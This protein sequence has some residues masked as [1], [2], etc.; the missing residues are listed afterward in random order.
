MTLHQINK[1]QYPASIERDWQLSLQ[2]GD[3]ILLFESG[4]LRA[5][6]STP[7]LSAQAPEQS[8]EQLKEQSTKQSVTL[9]VREIDAKAHGLKVDESIYQIIDDN[10]WLELTAECDRII[11]W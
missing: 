9:F 1:A 7:V 5:L 11:S 8:K 4:V 6:K 10:Q 3:S 2:N